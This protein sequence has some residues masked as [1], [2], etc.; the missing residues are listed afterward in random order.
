M[1]SSSGLYRPSD[2]FDFIKYNPV[3]IAPGFFLFV[4][5][6]KGNKMTIANRNIVD[7]YSGLFEGLDVMTNRKL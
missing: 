4:F 2:F 6:R 1:F 7:A 3:L 5:L